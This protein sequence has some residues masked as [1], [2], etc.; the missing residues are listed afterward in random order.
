M[1]LANTVVIL[2]GAWLAVSIPV[3]VVLG[4]LLRRADTS[5]PPDMTM[6]YANSTDEER[7]A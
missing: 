6:C 4:R 1:A 5:T 3:G 2:A 7:I